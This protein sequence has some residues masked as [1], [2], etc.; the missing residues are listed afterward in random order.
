LSLTRLSSSFRAEAHDLA[1][2]ID[3]FISDN[4]WNQVYTV[5]GA[6]AILAAQQAQQDRIDRNVAGMMKQCNS[7]LTDALCASFSAASMTSFQHLVNL[8]FVRHA[9]S[10]LQIAICMSNL[11][12]GAFLPLTYATRTCSVFAN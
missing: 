5:G 11:R 12:L 1:G 6:A 3:I 8:D 4:K 10:Y 7:L 2:A 9:N